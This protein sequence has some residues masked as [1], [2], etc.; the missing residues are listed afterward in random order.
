MQGSRTK[1]RK[2]LLPQA[3]LTQFL[4]NFTISLKSQ[5]CSA[6]FRFIIST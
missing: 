4:K 6:L 3:E 5:M 2:P 1:D